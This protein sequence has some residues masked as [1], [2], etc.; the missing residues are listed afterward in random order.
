M[1][2]HSLQLVLIGLLVLLITGCSEGPGGSSGGSGGGSGGGGTTSQTGSVVFWTDATRGWNRI[3]VSVSGSHK[4]S[5]T[6][7]LNSQ[8][9][10]CRT[11]ESQV[12]F[13]AKA[14]SYR[15]SASSDQGAEWNGT[16][17]VRA[18]TCTPV[19]LSCGSDRTCPTSGSENGGISTGQYMR[20][21]SHCIS[22]ESFFAVNSCNFR[23][24][25]HRCLTSGPLTSVQ[26]GQNPS[27]RNPYYTLLSF[28]DANSRTTIAESHESSHY[29]AC[30]ASYNGYQHSFRSYNDGSFSCYYGP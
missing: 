15:Y 17:T 10:S 5:L 8:P 24:A 4:G 3:D 27:S 19:H 16:I 7:F 6:R 13:T 23:V 2:K 26:C 25:V 14:G 11:R 29:V 21:V 18:N 22:L 28:V 1:V 12:V 30:R 9:T 20:D